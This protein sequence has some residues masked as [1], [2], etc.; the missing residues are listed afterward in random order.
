[1]GDLPKGG[2]RAL[3]EREIESLAADA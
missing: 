3:T 2:W 1:L